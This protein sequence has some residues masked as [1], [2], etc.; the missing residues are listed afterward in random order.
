LARRLRSPHAPHLQAIRL[1]H[2]SVPLGRHRAL[3]SVSFEL[4]AGQREMLDSA[5]V[6]PIAGGPVQRLRQLAVRQRSGGGGRAV[7]DPVSDR[8]APPSR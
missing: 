8:D 2:V 4:R 3:R 5:I 1:E 7:R 6:P